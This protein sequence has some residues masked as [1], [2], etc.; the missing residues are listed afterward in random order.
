MRAMAAAH[1]ASVAQV[2]LAWLLRREAVSSVLIGAT[3]LGQLEDN[4]RSAQLALT[5]AQVV[6]LE[7]ATELAGVYP[8]WFIDS[9]TSKR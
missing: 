6:E 1:G 8:N 5:D 3:K 7:A 2:A 4:L 9:W